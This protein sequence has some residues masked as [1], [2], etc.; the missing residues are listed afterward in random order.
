MESQ[1]IQ[2]LNNTVTQRI[3]GLSETKPIAYDAYQQL[4]DAYAAKIDTKPHNAFY[5]K[6]AMLSLLP[7]IQGQRV[8]DAGCGPGVYTEALVERGAIVDAIDISERMLELA[9]QRLQSQINDGKVALHLV[10]MTQPME[11]FADSYSIW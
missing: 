7:D 2:L 5:D 6:P 10:D 9:E 4:A 8:L 1:S 3:E 11:L